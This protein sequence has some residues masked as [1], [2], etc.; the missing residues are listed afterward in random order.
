MWK[1][2]MSYTV[3]TQIS[4]TAY[5]INRER[6]DNFIISYQFCLFDTFAIKLFTRY[7]R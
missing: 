2:E 4:F 6:F 3:N 5:K 7:I 1:R